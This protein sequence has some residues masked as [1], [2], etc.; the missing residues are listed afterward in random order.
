MRTS[1]PSFM[2]SDKF[3][4]FD[5]STLVCAVLKPQSTPAEALSWAWEVAKLAVSRETLAELSLVLGRAKFD[6]YRPRA[7]RD[8]FFARYQAMTLA[9]E[10]PSPV[11]LCRDPKD[12]KFRSLVAACGA[13]L[14]ISSDED[15]LTIGRFETALIVTP[16]QFVSLRE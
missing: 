7:D 3:V 9:C 1:T 14:L 6:A 5:I 2:S 16:G 8:E 12:D 4:V 13:S 11:V 15:L 10:V